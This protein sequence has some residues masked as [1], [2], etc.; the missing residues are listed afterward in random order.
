MLLAA[1]VD[2]IQQKGVL[3]IQCNEGLNE[4]RIHQNLASEFI[5]NTTSRFRHMS[6]NA[7]GK[8]SLKHVQ[9][10][11]CCSALSTTPIYCTYGRPK[12]EWIPA[13]LGPYQCDFNG[14]KVHLPSERLLWASL[15]SGQPPAKGTRFA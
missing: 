8:R 3:I 7:Q 2:F 9:R 13:S 15:P 5:S 4:I 12:A 14:R 6:H 1:T 11:A 10:A